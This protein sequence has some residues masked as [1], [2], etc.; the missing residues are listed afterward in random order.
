MIYDTQI[1]KLHP[2]IK[3]H[4][5]ENN[6]G[7]CG[8][9]FCPYEDKV[10]QLSCGHQFCTFCFEEHMKNK[11]KDGTTCLRAR[12]PALYCNIIIPHSFFLK[13]MKDGSDYNYLSK[14]NYWVT[15]A[16][17][18]NDKNIKWCP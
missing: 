5:N 12:C 14:Y 18:E 3:K 9:C 2:D 10:D 7:L 8:I 13:Y 17:T 15:K 6:E 4:L 1:D 11:V 16:Y